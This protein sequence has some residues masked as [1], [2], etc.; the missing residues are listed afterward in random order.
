MYDSLI[1]CQA[2]APSMG[3]PRQEYWSEEPVISSLGDLPDP[4]IKLRSPTLQ[5]DSL[6]TEL[7]G[8]PNSL[9]YV[10]D[11]PKLG[12]VFPTF[13]LSLAK[14]YDTDDGGQ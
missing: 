11:H 4:G 7:Q 14:G 5:A 1:A 10:K 9:A 12:H 2:P 13:N 3:F 6:P 8:K